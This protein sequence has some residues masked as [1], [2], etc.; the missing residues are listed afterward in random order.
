MKRL[1]PVFF[2][3]PVLAQTKKGL[4]QD[5][6]SKVAVVVSPALFVP[7]SVAV[8]AG[9]HVSIS[10]RFN[11]VTEFAYPTFRPANTAYEKINYWRTGVELRYLYRHKPGLHRYVAAQISYLSRKLTDEGQAFYYTK[12]QTFSYTNAVIKSPVLALALK[13]G[14][15]IPAG[16]RFFVDGFV[17]GGLR[18]IFTSY[19]TT[20]PLLTSLEPKQQTLLKFDDAWL[21]NYTLKRLHATAGLRLG[22]RL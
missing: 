9:L 11:L 16:K 7:V 6:A 3:L 5:T 19:Q 14:V 22:W 13:L 21:Y 2:F 20:N 1:L 4:A 10:P 18:A 15:E 12:T 17:G 8:Q